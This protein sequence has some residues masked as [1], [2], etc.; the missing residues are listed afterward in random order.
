MAHL[1]VCPNCGAPLPTQASLAAFAVCTY[2]RAT[3]N[4]ESRVVTERVERQ[5]AHDPSAPIWAQRIDATAAFQKAMATE[6]ASSPMSYGR[7]RE[8]CAK[9]LHPYG[10][11]DAVAHVAYSLAVDFEAE[12]GADVR[13]RGDVLARF[14]LAY[15]MAVEELRE[16]PTYDL[17][18]PFIVA[19]D[20]GPLHVQRTLD[21]PTLIALS[22][23]DPEVVEQ[24]VA[25][26][27]AAP[28]ASLAAAAPEPKRG[29]WSKF[30]G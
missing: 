19:T 9:Y 13:S 26:P 4:I 3:A 7:F 23:R 5:E 12:S 21:V 24:R 28:E 18:L 6:G 8:L 11:T 29:F 15:L 14:A 17:N 27:R 10:Q 25:E 30:F 20:M 2:C 22:E 1:I 16:K